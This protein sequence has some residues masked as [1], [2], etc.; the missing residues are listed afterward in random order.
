MARACKAVDQADLFGG[1]SKLVGPGVSVAGL[2]TLPLR[3]MIGLRHLKLGFIG[4]EEGF[5]EC[6]AATL[7]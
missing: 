7:I 5:I 3:L 2:P 6:L 4:S 1:I